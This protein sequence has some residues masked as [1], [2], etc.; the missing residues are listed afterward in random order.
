[1]GPRVGTGDIMGLVGR[2][3]K[4]RKGYLAQDRVKLNNVKEIFR[5]RLGL[6]LDAKR[7]ERKP[8][9]NARRGGATRSGR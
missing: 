5:E 6:A 8:V 3:V 4:P 2:A 9:W 1:M 7:L